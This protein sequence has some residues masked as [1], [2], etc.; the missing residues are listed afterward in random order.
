MTSDCKPT[1][2]FWITLALVAVLVVYPLSFGPACWWCS[3]TGVARLPIIYFPIGLAG[4]HD[5]RFIGK[6]ICWYA[7]IG[8]PEGS[9]VL[10]PVYPSGEGTSL[11]PTR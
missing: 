10:C 7:H 6:S 1:S 11:H 2:G 3:R 9:A 4:A 8:M 5:P